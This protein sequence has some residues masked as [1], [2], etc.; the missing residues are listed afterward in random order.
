MTIRLFATI[1]IFCCVLMPSEV[2]GKNCRYNDGEV[3]PG[4]R[5]GIYT[6]CED[7]RWKKICR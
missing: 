4:T 7:G 1:F 6:C 3:E 2:Y 5:K